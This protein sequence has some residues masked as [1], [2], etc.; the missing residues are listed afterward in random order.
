MPRL[1][2]TQRLFDSALA[3]VQG[4]GIALD[5]RSATSP[6]TRSELVD[7]LQGCDGVV[8]MLT[9]V[10]DRDLL[11]ANPGLRVVANVAVGHDNID[12][13]AAQRIGIA[14]TN[15]PGVLTGTTAD[16]TF[17]LLLAVAR[18]VVEAD[19]FARSGA[20]TRW[21]LEPAH[22][23]TDVHGAV[24]GLIGMGRI[25]QAVAQRAAHGFGMR[26]VYHSRRRLASDVEV[27][28]RATP[29]ALP[30]LLSQAQF[31][32][33][34]APATP[35]THHL[36]GPYE[37]EQMRP[38]AVLINTSRG[39]LVDE[40][41]LVAALRSASIAGAGLDVFEREPRIHADLVELREKVVLLP[42]VGSATVATRTQMAEMAMRNAIAALSG[43]EPPNLVQVG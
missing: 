20:R 39:S 19:A 22:I 40:D 24:L 27:A 41:A 36:I 37:L 26:V 32:T 7:A 16:L 11:E 6:M 10:I 34:H 13:A 14:V 38:D 18:R 9:D 21:E 8:C 29:A 42:H 23:G 25:G 1:L 30:A 12:V 2:V 17:A 33:F 31:V 28:L 35:E 15:T 3:L 43:Q 4:T 5:A